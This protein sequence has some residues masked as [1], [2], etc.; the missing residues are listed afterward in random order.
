MTFFFSFLESAVA[1]ARWSF[2]LL[3]AVA[4]DA[5]DAA[6]AADGRVNLRSLVALGMSL[7]R[8]RKKE[9]KHESLTYLHRR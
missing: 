4:V 6:D 8:R 9:R 7:G 1:D 2:G 3:A 5:L